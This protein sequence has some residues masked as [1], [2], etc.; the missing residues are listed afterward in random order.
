MVASICQALLQ[1]KFFGLETALRR[2]LL[3]ISIVRA[4]NFFKNFWLKLPSANDSGIIA[5]KGGIENA[6]VN[7][8]K[9]RSAKVRPEV[10]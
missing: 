1:K 8:S 3:V 9:A 4:Q 7:C 2:H 6:E 10:I 5:M